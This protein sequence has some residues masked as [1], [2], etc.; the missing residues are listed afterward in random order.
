[1]YPTNSV[2]FIWLTSAPKASGLCRPPRLEGL[3]ARHEA[4]AEVEY[5]AEEGR[6]FS[7]II[8]ELE[9]RLPPMLVEEV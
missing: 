1:M 8:T 6:L 4:E 3:Q 2:S 5:R 7:E 9:A